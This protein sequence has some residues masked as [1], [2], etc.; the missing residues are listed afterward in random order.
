MRLPPRPEV[1]GACA[2]SSG[3]GFDARLIWAG[4]FFSL[5]LFAKLPDLDLQIVPLYFSA[6][7]GFYLK[8]EPW[9][10]ALY[11]GT[12]PVGRSIVLLLAL[13]ALMAPW[14]AKGLQ[15]QGRE[16]HAQRCKGPWRRRA[17]VAVLCGVLGPGLLIEGVFKNSVG[18]PRP[19]Q[20]EQFGGDMAYQGPFQIGEHTARHRSFCSSHA[21]AG[22]W[23]MSFGLCCGPAWR[24]RWLL[25]GVLAGAA[26]GA[27]RMLQGGH[28][29]SDIL[30][31]FYSVWLCCE[32]VRWRLNRRSG[33]QP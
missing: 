29:F 5:A 1:K 30:F 6:E 21:A 10:Q 31:A 8:Q 15:R 18:R 4:L 14:L 9:V 26:I 7:G 24:R 20:V 22:F 16:A 32:L 2:Q 25:I 3:A 19:V 27:G 17:A 33:W 12:P 28:F 11:H 13:F 23:L